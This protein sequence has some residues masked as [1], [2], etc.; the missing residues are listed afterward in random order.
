MWDIKH[1][2]STFATCD[3][4]KTRRLILLL[5]LFSH[6]VMSDCLPPHGLQ[7]TRLPCP[8]LSPWVCSNAYPL[9]WWCIQPSHPLRPL[10]LLPSIFPR[11]R[12]FSSE[13]LFTSGGQSTGASPF[14][15][16]LLVNIQGWFHFELTG[17]ISLQ[18]MGR[19]R[20]FSNTI[21]QKHQFF[22]A[23][24]SL[25]SNAHPCM[26]SGKNKPLTIQ[27]VAGRVISLLFYMLFR[28]VIAFLPR[29][30]HL[31]FMAAV[32][33]CSDV[34]AQENKVCHCFHFSPSF[35]H[36][37]MGLDAMIF[38]IWMLSFKPAFSPCSLIFIK[39]SFS[40]SL[41]PAIR[42]VSSVYLR[43]LIFLLAILIPS[44]ASSSP[45]FHM[46]YSV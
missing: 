13:W 38:V 4:M 29:S 30:K 10:F 33:V 24:P 14:T 34:G 3:C 2:S 27:T 31:N 16:V 46:I 12:V 15:S 9:S 23:Q 43:L 20:V 21:F 19:S 42:V 39:E 26:T 17:L 7:H 18:S 22:S 37:I 28:F 25:W 45:A 41:L 5:F 40:S 8:S 44:C 1:F 36:E 35:C 11:I 6:T 32:I